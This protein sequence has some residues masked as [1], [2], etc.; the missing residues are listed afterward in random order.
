[1]RRG[2]ADEEAAGAVAAAADLAAN[3][4][5]RAAGAEREARRAAA[6]AALL[7]RYAAPLRHRCLHL[8]A[9]KALLTNQVRGSLHLTARTTFRT[10]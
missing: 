1:M 6:A 8:T 7:I 9:H 3:A 5:Q 10:R 4:T 2:R